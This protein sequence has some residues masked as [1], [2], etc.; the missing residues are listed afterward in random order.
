MKQLKLASVVLALLFLA[1]CPNTPQ[2]QTLPP[3]ALNQFDAASY[4]SLMGAQAVLNSV[5]ADINKLPPEAKPALNK[6]IASYNTA[7]AAWQAYHAGKS[8]DQA[9]LT[10]AITQ[11]VGDVTALLTQIS[12]GH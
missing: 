9:A 8:N 7:E 2:P 3:G 6:A 10:A 5:K 4:T 1:A 11:A 12:G